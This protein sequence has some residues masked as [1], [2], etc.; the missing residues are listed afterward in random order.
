MTRVTLRGLLG[1]KFRAILT[2]LAIVLGVAMVSGTYILTDTISKAFDNIFSGS[3]KNTSAVISGR[4]IVKFSSSGNATVP[5]SVLDRVKQLPSVGQASGAIFDL[6]SGANYAK[7][8]DRNGKTIGGQAPTLAFGFDPAASRFNPLTL[9]EGKWASGGGQIVIDAATARDHDFNVGDRIE[10]SAQGPIRNYRI[11]GIAKFGDVDSL[12]GATFATFDVA[13]AQKLLHKEGVFD[14][15]SV[16]SKSGVSP[17]QL[18]REIQPVLP[19]ST[20]VKTGAEQAKA[21]AKDTKEFTKLIQ[22]FL[23]AFGG[24]ALFVGAFVIFNTLSITVAQRA[25][26]FATLRTLGASRRQ[27]LRSVLLE[28]IVIGSL[29]SL[30]GLF[31]GLALAKGMSSAFAALGLDLPKSGTVFAARTVVVSLVLGIVIT[32]IASLAPALR[33]T[34]VPA[35]LAVRE[36]AQLPR[37]RIAPFAP[38][39]AAVTV[40]VGLLLLAYAMFVNGLA[41]KQRLAVL[42]VGLLIL[43]VGV[44]LISSRIVRPLAALVGAPAERTG[45]VA[46]RL[47]RENAVRNPGRTASTAAALMIGLA[48]VTVVATLGAG[49]R[50]ADR[51]A[52]NRQVRSDYVVTSKNGFDPF[53]VTAGEALASAKGLDVVSD[54]RNEHARLFR[55]DVTVDGVD[56]TTITKVFQFD[57]AKGSSDPFNYLSSAGNQPTYLGLSSAIVRKKFADKHRLELGDPLRITTP[58]GK[59]KSFQVFAVY[60]PPKIDSLDP[61]LGSIL[62]TNAAFD[63][64]FARP[65]NI[66]T[67]VKAEGGAGEATTVALKQALVAYPDAKVQTK[68]KWVNQRAAGVNKLLNLLYVLL[69]LSVVVSL[70]GMVNTLVLSVFERT[71]EIGMLRAVGMTRR[72]TR[73]M[74]RHESVITALIG[75]ALGLPLGIVLAALVSQAMS[76]QGLSFR[77]PVVSLLL[78]AA[79]AV[80]AGMLAAIVPARRAARLNVL[81]ALQYE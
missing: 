43:F 65:K 72:Q 6:T 71:R 53:P 32:L 19:P 76:E 54:V 55:S 62:I 70:F 68:Q 67:F 4:Q 30:I 31:L 74:I 9:G 1:R 29:A 23:L 14:A 3:Y 42:A 64:T 58:D 60:E 50:A 5:A 41:T 15:I 33:A 21:N 8:I 27:V 44:A 2:A 35:I 10:V 45:G 11:S 52:L 24:I 40:V 49:L 34:R 51:D 7:L 36:G 37:S 80:V 47:A 26:E 77:L 22:L 63:R 28:G 59:H 79:V 56:P 48:L 17:E 16:A 57:W 39:L 75:A 66:Y 46:G 25:R 69:A 81:K 61:V 18:K 78:F 73:R 12:G 13:T 20:E 38:A